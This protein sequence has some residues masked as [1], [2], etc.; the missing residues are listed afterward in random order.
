M[1]TMMEFIDPP[2]QTN[3]TVMIDPTNQWIVLFDG[4]NNL[5]QFDDLNQTNCYRST[6]LEIVTNHFI[7]SCLAILYSCT[8]ILSLIGNI[9]VILVQ[10]F[11][12]EHGHHF[13]R[14]LINLAISDIIIGVFCVPFTYTDFVLRQWTFPHWL[15]PTAQFVQLLSVFI[16]AN[17]LAIIGIERAIATLYPL[18]EAH[19][20][21]QRHTNHL[22]ASTWMCG[23]LYAY[24][25]Y[26]HTYTRQYG[27]NGHSFYQC[28]YDNGLT[29]EKRR[30]L[31]TLNF[32]LTFAMPSII[33][34]IS[35]VAIMKQ[36]H[37][38]G[39]IRSCGYRYHT[40]SNSPPEV[41]SHIHLIRLP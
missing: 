28:S 32:I 18:T 38:R 1:M 25:P 15:C 33:L 9:M 6:S 11:A 22:I 7:Q 16:T 36:L 2:H 17:T 29:V 4:A 20:W 40:P 37:H 10:L 3:E 27:L 13:R 19:Q 12:K 30:L 23:I 39:H 41:Y 35:Y 14:Y 34:T 5:D 24:V 21:M 8:A 31:M 26:S